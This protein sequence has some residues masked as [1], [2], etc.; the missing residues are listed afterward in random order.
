MTGPLLV[1]LDVDGTLLSYTED[2]AEEVAAAVAAV[3][4]AGHH[5][6]IATGRSVHATMPVV[7]RLG[8]ETGWA[9][10]S[11]GS[12]TVRLDPAA[13]EGYTAH[14]IVTFD[15]APALR[16]LHAQMPDAFFAVEDVGVGFRM[17][18]LFP[19]GELHGEHTVV[20]IDDLAGA[21]VT[22]LIVR[23]P[24]HTSQE[25][26]ALVLETGLADV[27]YAIGWTAWMDVA[28]Q[29]VT[30]ASALEQVRTTLG[31]PSGRTVAL[32][33]GNNDIDMLRWAGRGVA[34][35]H[36][37]AEVRAAADEVTGSIDE[38]GAA[39]LLRSLLG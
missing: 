39:L 37:S 13:P 38:D 23:S 24:G 17:N 16:L 15:P 2:L 7:R 29:G 4:D 11:N 32:G 28:P 3:R 14:E 19:N 1:A 26:H 8:I 9:V 31:V 25:F 5:V 34:M 21:H 33:D 18:K 22:R 35:G 30:K 6:V 10:C 12:V 20:G 27:T 36:A